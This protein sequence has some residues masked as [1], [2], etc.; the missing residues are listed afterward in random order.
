MFG[1]I[2]PV[3]DLDFPIKFNRAILYLVKKTIL[4]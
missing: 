2:F 1:I 3:S 4:F